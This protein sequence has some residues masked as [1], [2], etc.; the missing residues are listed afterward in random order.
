M[1][2]IVLA[3]AVLALFACTFTVAEENAVSDAPRFA[4]VEHEDAA[5]LSEQEAE[6]NALI[7][8][9]EEEGEE[10]GEDEADEE[11]DEE[12]EEADEA[13]GEEEVEADSEE[14]EADETEDEEAAEDEE[15]DEDNEEEEE[16]ES[17]EAEEAESEGNS[18]YVLAEL[19]DNA[20]M[21][22]FMEMIAR[23]VPTAARTAEHMVHSLSSHQQAAAE[24]QY[25]YGYAHGHADAS[26]AQTKADDEDTDTEEESE[27]A[28][29]ASFVEGSAKAESEV[30]VYTAQYYAGYPNVAGVYYH[31]Y[32]PIPAPPQLPTWLPP[33]P[34]ITPAPSKAAAA[35]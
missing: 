26:A 9:D 5:T 30:P 35:E 24:Q 7:A 14:E 10:E 12:A 34:Y 28:D 6:Y 21:T 11:V 3:I 25:A 33:P 29:E 16:E 4:E 32:G 20:V 27:E 31:P 17:D 2:T 22:G 13:E 18:D 8:S 1:R 19:K 23:F 15:A